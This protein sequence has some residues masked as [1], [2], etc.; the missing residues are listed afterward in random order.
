MNIRE[1]FSCMRFYQPEFE[2]VVKQYRTVSQSSGGNI[3]VLEEYIERRKVHTLERLKVC[4]AVC[5]TRSRP[6]ST[7]PSDRSFQFH[8]AVVKWARDR[9]RA[10]NAAK[11]SRAIDRLH[12]TMAD[13]L[14]MFH[15][16][17]W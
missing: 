8:S 4:H 10:R 17:A 11:I 6:H 2:A 3:K 16:K 12:R 14:A 5:L 9:E 7:V 15:D 13:I 1:S